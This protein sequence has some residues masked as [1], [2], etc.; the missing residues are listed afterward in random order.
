M[1]PYY[2]ATYTKILPTKK[3]NF[4]DKQNTIILCNELLNLS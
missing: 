3:Y 4:Y 1:Y 2:L